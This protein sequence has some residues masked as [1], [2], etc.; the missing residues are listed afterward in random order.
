MS[1]TKTFLGRTAAFTIAGLVVALGFS[2]T[3]I[4]GVGVGVAPDFPATVSVGQTNI[5]VGLEIT[6]N[7]TPD[8]GSITLSN[9]RL[10]PSCGDSDSDSTTCAGA[11][12]DPGVFTASA[13]GT[14]SLACSANTFTIAINDATT[15]QLLFTPNAP[16]ALAPGDTCRINFTVNVVQMAVDDSSPN[17]GIQT[18]QIGRVFGANDG[19]SGTGLGTDETTV[20][21]QGHIIVNKVT[22]PS[23]DPQSF[24]FD[25]T[26]TGYNDFSLTDTA[27]PN[28]QTLS[29]GTYSVS[30]TLPSGWTQTSAT[31]VSSLGNSETIGNISLQAGETVTCTFT[32]TKKGHIIVNKVTNPSGSTQSFN[33]DA[34]GTGYND[35]S[36]TDA[37][38]PNDQEVVPGAYS[39]SEGA[40]AGWTQTSAICDQ[41]ET[42][43]SLDVGA[44]ETVTC[45]FTNT[46][47]QGHIIVN[48]VTNPSGDPQ[49]FSFDATGTGYNDFSLTDVATPND[50][51]L[52]AGTY[53]VSETLPSGWTQTSA[54]CVS[55]IEDTESIGSLEL[56][57]G[58]TITCTFTNTKKGH[59][60]VD[61]ITNPSGSTQSFN[62]TATGTGYSNFALTDAATPNNQEVV[63]GAYTIS[64]GAV[65]GW[66]SNGGVC[67]NGEA[68]N[69]IDVGPG[70]TITC[71]FTNTQ[72]MA[73]IIV[74]KVTLPSGDTQSFSFDA[75][76]TGYN[77]FSLTDAA[78][79]NDQV[80]VAGTYS[81]SETLP[82]GWTQTS[83]VCDQ[84]ETID[85]IDVAAGETVTC[86]FTN[87]KKGHII[88]NKVTDPS[89]STQS[90]NFD[91]SG[92]GYNDF[93]LT[94][95]AAPNNQ[96]VVPGAYSVS[97]G[98][99]AGWT[100]TSAVCDQGETPASLDVEPGETVSCTFTNTQ[101]MGHIII[102]KQTNPDGD[103]QSF[104][105]DSNY[106]NN[107]NLVD[108][109]QND[110]GALAA[111]TYNVAEIN[112]PDN[113]AF[114]SATCSDGSNVNNIQLA[115]GETVTCTF[116][117]T[118]TPPATQGCSPGYWKQSQHFGSYPDGIYPNTT[119]QS[120]FGSNA[121]GNK[122]LLQ[123]LSQG[124]GGLNALG[125]IM[126]AAYLN[127]A[128][129]EDFAYTPEEVI[130][131]FNDATPATYGS[132][133]ATFEALQDPCPFGKNPGPAGPEQQAA[134]TN[135]ADTKPKGKKESTPP[136]EP[137]ATTETT[138]PPTDTTTTGTTPTTT[139]ESSTAQGSE[140]PTET[141]TQ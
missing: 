41:G 88:V 83:A 68:P 105:F 6:N 97:E 7:S 45:T 130:E 94:D 99:V 70:E 101:Q 135:T 116:T 92:T 43:E 90:F 64:E 113:W 39:I 57:A 21:P 82:S 18:L 33:F 4:A 48:K 77:D 127:A 141:T 139:T 133:K 9:I 121:F 56:D 104:E 78:A 24:N 119:F 44:G 15:G 131:A 10:I 118:Y 37:A 81:V 138:T 29:A 91:A 42:I 120:V 8:V 122:T 52:N 123:V 40:V 69:S 109:G 98:A 102:V 36:L 95:A 34:N 14:G 75:T 114:S 134:L 31:C 60:I 80:V 25:A 74:N 63:P 38:A 93:S 35:F 72:Q 5:P 49:S 16:I 11:E 20:V 79:P 136:T 50:Q 17:A 59:I 137:A 61:K 129:I 51:T 22:N 96:E 117:N 26:G 124:G 13:T 126:V 65:A 19:L 128:T 110:S 66:D 84:G 2:M 76:G 53:S 87:T 46:Q 89:G 132:V 54:T 85:S 3:A 12:V 23:G 107:F 71:T 27:T 55:S 47:Q 73:H 100:Q 125:R 111:G 140:T 67:D 112:M 32:N 103:P 62:F 28:D 30:E 1:I 58:E 115:A 86:T 108:G 106:G